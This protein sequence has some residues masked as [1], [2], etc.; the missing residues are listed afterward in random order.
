VVSPETTIIVEPLKPD[1]TVDFHEAIQE[2]L[3]Q[4]ALPEENGFRDVVL[5]YGQEIFAGG[6][7]RDDALLYALMCEELG[8]TPEILPM[9]G[10]DDDKLAADK[11]DAVRVAAAKPHYFI[12]LVRESDRDFAAFSQPFAVYE[13]HERLSDALLSRAKERFAP[14][15]ADTHDVDSQDVEDAWKDILTSIRLFRRATVN[16]AWLRMLRGNAVETPLTP[17]AWV[18]ETLPHWTPEQLEQ[19]VKDLESL[20]AWQDRQTTLRILQFQVLDILSATHDLHYLIYRLGAA[21][22]HELLGGQPT[23][24]IE[25]LNLIAFDWNAAARELNSAVRKYGDLTAQA[26]EKGFEEQLELLRLGESFALPSN[27]EEAARFFVH[28][29]EGDSSLNPFFALGRSKL[30]G[31]LAGH[32]VI[33]AAGEMYRLQIMEEA[34]CEALRWALALELFH[35]EGGHYPDALEETGLQP[36]NPNMLFEYEKRGTGYRIHNKIFQLVRE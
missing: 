9:P 17:A 5:R 32:W 12:P 34:R 27:E 19:A 8:I 10:L 16:Q 14:H 30:A 1:G 18:A 28:M 15:D 11:L 4:D 25:A 33:W 24:M 7:E 22:Q 13:F 23:E 2:I 26:V 3:R 35:R 36:M 21:H 29:L 31:I 6:W 20:P